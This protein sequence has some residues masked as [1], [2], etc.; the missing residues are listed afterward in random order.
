MTKKIKPTIGVLYIFKFPSYVTTWRLYRTD[1]DGFFHFL[2]ST[3]KKVERISLSRFQYLC[4]SY[5]IDTVRCD[6]LGLSTINEPARFERVKITIETSSS[7]K[8]K[9]YS[10]E[11]LESLVDNIEDVEF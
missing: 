9:D 8:S 7:F 11:E 5:L 3:G 2:S 4:R 1:E 6:C 10:R